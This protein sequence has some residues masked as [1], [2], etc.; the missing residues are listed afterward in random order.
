MAIS[1]D[2]VSGFSLNKSP[3]GKVEHGRNF[4]LVSIH[5]L[6]DYFTYLCL[7]MQ[8]IFKFIF[9]TLASNCPN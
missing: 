7:E 6:F 3:A 9:S 8:M 5:D 1:M 2:P 4:K